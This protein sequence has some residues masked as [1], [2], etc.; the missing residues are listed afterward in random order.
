MI[1]WQVGRLVHESQTCKYPF[2]WRKMRCVAYEGS[3]KGQYEGWIKLTRAKY[4]GLLS[5]PVGT[6]SM[7]QQSTASKN[8]A[9]D[10]QPRGKTEREEEGNISEKMSFTTAVR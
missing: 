8:L 7:R 3:L 5:A 6:E 1:A 10:D 4:V 2:G 9:E